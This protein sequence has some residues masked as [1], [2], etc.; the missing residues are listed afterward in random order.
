MPDLTLLQIP[1]AHSFIKSLILMNKIIINPAAFFL[2]FSFTL[3]FRISVGQPLSG[4]LQESRITA[5]DSGIQ[6]EN[7]GNWDAI[8]EMARKLNKYIFVDCYATW[9]GPCKVM[10]RDVYPRKE[11]GDFMNAR[12]ISIKVQLDTSKN[13]TEEIKQ[14][15]A[16]ARD[17]ASTYKVQVLPTYLFFSPDGKLVHKET[18]SRTVKNFL[19]AASN[20]LDPAMQYYTLL[21]KW[22]EK[23]VKIESLPV[24]AKLAQRYN[25]HSIANDIAREYMLKY[26]D[27]LADTQL[28]KKENL[29]FLVGNNG[30]ITTKDKAFNF[31]RNNSTVIDSSV[32][33]KYFADR[34]VNSI[35]FRDYVRPALDSAKISGKVPGWKDI[36]GAI[37]EQYGNHIAER[38]IVDGMVAWTYWKKDWAGF[39]RNLIRQAKYDL[40][41]GAFG[42]NSRAMEILTHS[43]K[44]KELLTASSWLG[45]AIALAT[46]EK[47]VPNYMDTKANLLYKAGKSREA[48]GIQKGAIELAERVLKTLPE[49]QK[50]HYGKFI[51]LLR[52]KLNKME[53]RQPT[54]E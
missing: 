18:G 17:M 16:T 7:D 53:T 43:K 13:D 33:E 23:K 22:R 12:F 48:I 30:I 42:L 2:M 50:N 49:R 4:D 20:A 27:N 31:F 36:R 6:F 29:T 14:W 44:K 37:K 24:L 15:Y 47:S 39:T 40:S 38:L 45:E 9:C 11:V 41:P 10:D 35:I 46:D 1:T 32:S 26:L 21:D 5:M 3:M 54:W 19:V 34:V 25:D 52:E 28:V 8:K 51:G